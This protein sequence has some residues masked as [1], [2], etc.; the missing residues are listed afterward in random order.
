VADYSP[1]A[2]TQLMRT[3]KG[4]GERDLKLMSE[5]AR[6]RFVNFTDEEISE[7]Y[8][9]LMTRASH[10]ITVSLDHLP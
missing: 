9:Y 7:L 2:F 8:R 10:P 3:G 5:V 4:L 6:S 1:E